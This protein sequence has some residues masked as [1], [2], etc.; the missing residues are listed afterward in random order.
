L[1]PVG[2][3]VTGQVLTVRYGEVAEEGKVSYYTVQIRRDD[4]SPLNLRMTY[5]VQDALFGPPYLGSP[6]RQRWEAFRDQRRRE[7]KPPGN[8]PDGQSS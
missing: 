1:T 2:V 4:G 6:E 3:R 7:R 8:D 5:L